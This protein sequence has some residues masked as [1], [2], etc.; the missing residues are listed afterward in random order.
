MEIEPIS[1]KINID[2]TPIHAF[3]SLTSQTEL[4]KWW[5][6]R[7][8]MS[9]H[10][11]SVEEGKD[12]EMRLL[13]SDKNQMVRYSWRPS[14]W[15]HET[16]E[17]VITFEI[18]DLG[19]SRSRTGEGISLLV[20]HDGWTNDKERDK[21]EK[22]LKPAMNCLKLILEGK[23]GKPWWESERT[24]SGYRQVK[25]SVL[26]Q[27]VERIDRDH[28]GKPEKKLAA[29]NIFKLC[30]NLD[31]QGDWFIK[32]SGAEIDLRFN[33]T[34]IIGI[35]KNGNISLGWRELDKVLGSALK[36]FADRLS[37][38]QNTE[39][40]IGKTQDKIS[41]HLIE[42]DA[43]TQWCIDAIQHVRGSE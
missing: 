5:A 7:V 12:I 9:K 24:R 3:R 6:P 43:L 33:N 28:R 38:E 30:Q 4:R 20:I 39:L 21:Q 36:D 11:V 18:E 41:A 25:F 34:K 23:T 19:V 15:G 8:I 29:Q 37:S 27:F 16:P 31:G 32:D 10:I 14:D 22:I 17:T 13:Q 2:T 40:H 1:I 35:V 26:K 42:V